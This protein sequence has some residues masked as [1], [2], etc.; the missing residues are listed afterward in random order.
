MFY[1]S[2]TNN[3]HTI[4]SIFA[5]DGARSSNSNTTNQYSLQGLEGG[6]WALTLHSYILPLSKPSSKIYFN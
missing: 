5:D 6:W 2:Q 1:Y 4:K 3:Y